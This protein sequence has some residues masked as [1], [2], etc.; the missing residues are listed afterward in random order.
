MKKPTLEA[1]TGK[2]HLSYSGFDN[3][4]QCGEKYRL[5]RVLNVPEGQAWWF[6]GGTAIH[7]ATEMWD[8]GD[9]RSL[10]DIWN[11]AW[12]EAN[13]EVD[14]TQP[15][16]AGGRVSKQWPNKEDHTWWA[17]HGPQMLEKYVRWRDTSGWN[18]YTIGDTPVIEW[19]FMLTLESTLEG[20]DVSPALQVKGQ[21]DRVFV[22]PDGEVVVIDI[23]AGSR[24]PASTTQLGIYCAALRQSGG[25]DP[26]L[27]GYY[28]TRKGESPY[29][30]GMGMYTDR[31]V[32]HWLAVFE[33][34]VRQKR[35]LP[36]VT[37]MCQTCMV[38]PYCYAVGGQPPDG[39]P[40]KSKE[41]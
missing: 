22:T 35:F 27:G 10:I 29:L 31:L 24:E 16:R 8:K 7:T 4:Q 33:D 40:L 21:I 34:T 3:F 18:L 5:T 12:T 41:A 37:S 1:L 39:G 6:I 9:A 11:A 38:A 14:N 28:M 30:R 13:K 19:D 26:A 15:I 20:D 25:V 32:A 2:K 23:K 36:H 17:F